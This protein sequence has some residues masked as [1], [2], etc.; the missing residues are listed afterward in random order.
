MGLIESLFLMFNK[1][2]NVHARADE[3][4]YDEVNIPQAWRW[5]VG[6]MLD[7]IRGNGRFTASS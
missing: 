2:K 4:R 7:G 5:W 1:W 3:I 6:E